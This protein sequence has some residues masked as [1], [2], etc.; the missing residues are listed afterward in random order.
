MCKRFLIV[1]VEDCHVKLVEKVLIS[2]G[3]ETAVRMIG[4]GGGIRE[5]LPH[6]IDVYKS[7]IIGVVPTEKV[8]FIM[9]QL[10]EEA[11][12]SILGRGVAFDLPAKM[13]DEWLKTDTKP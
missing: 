7:V 9:K 11:E 4:M 8:E 10:R 2:A 6:H 1:V 5:L 12:F 13:M 3:L